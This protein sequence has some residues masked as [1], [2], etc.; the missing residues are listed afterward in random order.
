MK[1]KTIHE[2]DFAA[3]RAIVGG[4]NI[5]D[6]TCTGDCVCACDDSREAPEASTKDSNN[7]WQAD[8]TMAKTQ[9]NNL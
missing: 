3:Q 7:K 5:G 2:L 4:S 9:A 6:C 8:Q 1:L